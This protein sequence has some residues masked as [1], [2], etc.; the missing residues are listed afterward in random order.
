MC[1]DR[2]PSKINDNVKN[3]IKWKNS[4]YKNYKRNGKKTEDCELSLY[5]KL[6]LYLKFL[7]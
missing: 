3:K 2:D 4:I 5:L 6:R 1:N 7:D